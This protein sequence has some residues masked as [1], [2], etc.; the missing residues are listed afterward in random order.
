MEMVKC[1]I[2][3]LS[4]NLEGIEY[5]GHV[6]PRSIAKVG[7]VVRKSIGGADYKVIAVQG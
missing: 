3:F 5:P 6:L 4:G 1:T 2:V 7:H